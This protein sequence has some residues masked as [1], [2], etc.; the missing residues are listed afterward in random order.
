MRLYVRNSCWCS[1]SGCIDATKE[2]TSVLR[3]VNDTGGA[4]WA[5]NISANS[6][7]HI[8]IIRGLG[9]LIHVEN[10]LSKI[11]WHCPFKFVGRHLTGFCFNCVNLG[12]KERTEEKCSSFTVTSS[13]V[14][15]FY[16]WQSIYEVTIKTQNPKCRHYW[17]LIEFIDWRYSQSCFFMFWSLLWTVAPLPSLWPPPSLPAFPK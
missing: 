12:A 16:G 13:L 7:R 2:C 17:C 6:K 8:G 3:N 15:R 14:F 11:S 10:L 9:K 4:P 5:A 1:G